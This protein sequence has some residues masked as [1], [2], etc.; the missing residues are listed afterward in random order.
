MTS[1][2]PPTAR[3]RSL[4]R[5]LLRELPSRPRAPPSPVQQRIRNALASDA[6]A[7]TITTSSSS[8]STTAPPSARHARQLD[9]AE[10]FLQYVRAQRTYATLLERYNPGMGMDEEER[11]RLTMRRVGLDA[12]VEWKGKGKE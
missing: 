11:A 12:P 9:Q 10:Q 6:P 8:S 7:E 4:Y 3:L 5:S 1:S 2:T